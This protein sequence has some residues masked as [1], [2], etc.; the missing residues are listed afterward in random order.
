[1]RTIYSSD[2]LVGNRQAGWQSVIRDVYANLEIEI[3]P[4]VG[5]SGRI[6]RSIIGE[7][8]LTKVRTDG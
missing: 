1:M 5:F 4:K 3:A 7:A 8:E 6:S 2:N